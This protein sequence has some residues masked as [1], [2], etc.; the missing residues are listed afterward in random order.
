MHPHRGIE[1]VT[2]LLEGEVWHKDSI[3]N[4]GS[5]GSGDAQWMTAGSGIMHHEMP[6]G[7]SGL[8]GFQLWVNLPS[9]HKM[10]DPRYRGIISNQIPETS[11]GKNSSVKIIAGEFNG[12]K[13]AF[14]DIYADPIYLDINIKGADTI[15]I[16]LPTNYNSFIYVFDNKLLINDTKIVAGDV[17]LFNQDG[18]N[19]KV[20]TDLA[21]SRFLIAAGKPLNEPIAWY[22]PIV[23]NTEEE[24]YIARN[25][26]ISGSFIKS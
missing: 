21:G 26:L 24:L 7:S 13:A 22:G 11:I 4:G 12:N 3:G 16:P 17:V 20:S 6:K 23:M 18:D 25:E 5:I 14:N 15:E 10:S 9:Q 8:K 19:I 2:Y 1:T